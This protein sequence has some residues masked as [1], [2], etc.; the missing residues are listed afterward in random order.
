MHG[1]D[2]AACEHTSLLVK[3]KLL[4]WRKGQA[5]RHNRKRE[6]KGQ[7][8]NQGHKII[9]IL[10][11]HNEPF[12]C[13]SSNMEVCFKAYCHTIIGG[14]AATSELNA[15]CLFYL[16]WW[17]RPHN[18]CI[19]LVVW[20]VELY[21]SNL[22]GVFTSLLRLQLDQPCYKIVYTTLGQ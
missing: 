15:R 12:T 5:Y 4:D 10:V 8:Q 14:R 11:S 17:L 16:S 7:N 2:Y 20:L 9:A 19:L 1:I 22:S 6:K 13:Y 18:A 3:M 21:S